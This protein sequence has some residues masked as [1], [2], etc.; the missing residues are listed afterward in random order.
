MLS[1]T[2]NY[3]C[4]LL[5]QN[6][7]SIYLFTAI[8]LA[9]MSV[10]KICLGADH[11]PVSLQLFHPL[12]TSPDP[13]TDT[14]VRLG[15]IFG[16]S[17]NIAGFDACGVISVTDGC[18]SGVQ[19]TGLYSRVGGSFAGFSANIGLQIHQ[20]PAAGFQYSGLANFHYNFFTGA[21]FCCVLNYTGKGFRG[22]QISGLMNL[23]D[24][25]G[26]FL[27]VG[28]I[29]NVNVGTFGGMQLAAVMNFAG[30]KASGGQYALLNYAARLKGVQIGL[31]NI[32]EDMSGVQLGALNISR[33]IAGVPVGLINLT[34]DGQVNCVVYASNLSLY[35]LGLRTVA[36]N[37]SS[38]VS[39]G[40]SD[41]TS[42]AVNSL[43]LGWH[44]GRLFPISHRLGLTADV[45]YLHIVPGDYN[46]SQINNDVHYA[47]QIRLFA[48][49]R[50]TNSFSMIGGVGSS[51]VF[52]DYTSHARFTTE[53]HV[54]GGIILFNL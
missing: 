22:A 18:F 36:N 3:K 13:E 40:Y 48:D 31:V 32:T 26:G 41:Q 53:G 37:W 6:V 2:S 42:D 24:G 14:N 5:R 39:L 4:R 10:P 21:Q 15:L 19:L 54:F 46:D 38:V 50:L 11:L 1:I 8:A 35:N 27:Q 17:G 52:S 7:T 49:Y 44:F 33:R 9:A 34:D 23:N 51:K 30:A 43:F 29:A 28:S 20:G 47:L 45:G 16:R 25:T 12:A